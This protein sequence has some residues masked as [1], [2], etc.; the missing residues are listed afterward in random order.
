MTNEELQQILAANN[1][2][3]LNTF[4]TMLTQQTQQF[5][6]LLGQAKTVFY[7][8][9]YNDGSAHG[10]VTA[11]DALKPAISDGLRHGSPEC[12][13]AMQSFRSLGLE[14]EE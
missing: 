7:T 6:Q 4:N 12:G 13:K 10:Y 3:M 5:E 11:I 8:Q 14:D 1:Q 9:G 2:M